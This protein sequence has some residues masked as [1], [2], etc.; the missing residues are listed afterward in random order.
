MDADYGRNFD[1]KDAY[2]SEF[3]QSLYVLSTVVSVTPG[4]RAVL[5]AGLKAV[6]LDSGVPVLADHT[7]LIFH[8]GGDEHGIVTPAG[9]L[10][11]I[12]R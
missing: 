12:T 3:R 11:V 9:N 6:S 7:D 5:D 1:Q 10:K 4:K 2:I 8:N